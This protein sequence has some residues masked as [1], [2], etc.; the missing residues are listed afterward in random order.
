[1]EAF[2]DP[3]QLALPKAR[4]LRASLELLRAGGLSP[5]RHV[6][7]QELASGEICLR[8][9]RLRDIPSLVAAGSVDVGIAPDE[10]IRETGSD[11]LRLERL[12]WYQGTVSLIAPERTPLLDLPFE[13]WP[14]M[15]V[16]TE[17]PR[18]ASDF[19]REHDIEHEILSIHGAA[20]GYVPD[21]ADASID[22]VETGDT[23]RRHALVQVTQILECEVHLI[24][25]P[26]APESL[27]RSPWVQALREAARNLE[28]L[29]PAGK[30]G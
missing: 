10:W 4:L 9:L 1:M 18:L 2:G 30:D 25:R 29:I 8:L 26:D 16:A 3:L 11:V 28:E 23:I 6:Y 24:A 27:L 17:Y 20:E 12:G 7:R 14:R 13:Q 19:L 21:L 22:I 5:D 15:K